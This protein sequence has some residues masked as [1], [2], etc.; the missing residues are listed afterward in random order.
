MSPNLEESTY[1]TDA[2]VRSMR[3]AHGDV[4]AVHSKSPVTGGERH[5]LNPVC[6]VSPIRSNK[7]WQKGA[8]ALTADELPALR[9][10]DYGKKNNLA[11]PI[12]VF[13]TAGTGEIVRLTPPP[14]RH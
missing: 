5:R 10:S 9:A 12:T 8:P 13:M 4:L 6:D 1:P 7:A 3:R 14:M 2:A 11:D